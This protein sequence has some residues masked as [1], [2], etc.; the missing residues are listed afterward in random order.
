MGNPTGH[1]QLPT[2]A[3]GLGLRAG[4]PRNPGYSRDQKSGR[5]SDCEKRGAGFMGEPVC[6]G[7]L[8]FFTEEEAKTE[9]WGWGEQKGTKGRE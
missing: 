6:L 8:S 2:S 7:C 5:R 1:H 3:A 9:V 4:W